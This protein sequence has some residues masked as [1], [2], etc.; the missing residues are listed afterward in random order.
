MSR[1]DATVGT[2]QGDAEHAKIVAIPAYRQ[3]LALHAKDKLVS[4]AEA[5][6]A[7]AVENPEAGVWVEPPS[8]R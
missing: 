4:L 7:I 6:G 3:F 2:V 8:R 1:Q 5:V